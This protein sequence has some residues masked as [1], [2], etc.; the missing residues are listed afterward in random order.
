VVLVFR[1]PGEPPQTKEFRDEEQVE[2]EANEGDDN[3]CQNTVDGHVGE[4]W[5]LT[6]QV[7][8]HCRFP[9]Q[10]SEEQPPVK[11]DRKY[12]CEKVGE[13]TP[14]EMRYPKQGTQ[15]VRQEEKSDN[16]KCERTKPHA[17][18]GASVD[19]GGLF[20][21]DALKRISLSPS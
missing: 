4:E 3:F 9:F 5:Y 20:C 14:R 2:N 7:D 11:R 6:K 15:N 13:E 19:G 16:Q 18:G 12:E 21:C 1:C 17:K 8:A 10:F